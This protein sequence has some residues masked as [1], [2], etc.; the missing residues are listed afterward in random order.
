MVS[1]FA[2]KVDIAFPPNFLICLS[3][4]P[5]CQVFVKVFFQKSKKTIFY[6]SFSPF[7]S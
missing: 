4:I 7:I 3:I 1:A 2:I 5:C 6:L